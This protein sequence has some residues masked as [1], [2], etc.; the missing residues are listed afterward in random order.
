MKFK[1][2]SSIFQITVGL[3]A[4]ISFIIILINGGVVI[5][6]IIS[7]ILGILFLIQGI[8]GIKD[9]IKERTK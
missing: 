8:V 6:W 4:V 2:I 7:F 9:Y 3:L 5:K 1:L